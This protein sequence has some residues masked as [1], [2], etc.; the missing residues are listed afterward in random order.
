ME[1]DE[2]R[3]IFYTQQLSNE[4][5]IVRDALRQIFF[6]S[7][8]I[9]LGI[10]F[11]WYT[12]SSNLTSGIPQF[13]IYLYAVPFII[14]VTTILLSINMFD[15]ANEYCKLNQR[16]MIDEDTKEIN[17]LRI[18]KSITLNFLDRYIKICFRVSA[19]LFTLLVLMSI[20]Y[21]NQPIPKG[22]RNTTIGNELIQSVTCNTEKTLVPTNGAN[23]K[24]STNTTPTTN[25][26]PTKPSNK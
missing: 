24:Q 2:F 14:S 23:P 6:F 15:H 11:G 5:E 13:V 22:N 26:P 16:L 1:D 10:L 18:Q 9:I 25:T 17:E 19:G 20:Y 21:M 7:Y 8:S 4:V 3:K 12:L